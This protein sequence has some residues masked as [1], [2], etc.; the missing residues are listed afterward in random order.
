MKSSP[1]SELMERLVG[2]TCSELFTAYGVSLRRMPAATPLTEAWND[3]ASGGLV[4]FDSPSMTGSLVLV[5]TFR[6]LASCR[7]KEV[8]TRPL[9]RES[10]AD[11]ILVRDWTT[12]LVNQLLGRVRNRLYA[13]GVALD[14]KNPVALS[15]HSLGMAMKPRPKATFEFAAADG[16]IVRVWL[17]TR[18]NPTFA[19]AP[20]KDAA[21][22]P[23]EGDVL[24]F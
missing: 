15:G 2:E 24:L 12:E 13:R 19:P 23:E 5:G 17:D 11:W 7:P 21:A 6:F 9:K 8:R 3:E 22:V 20:P 18:F 14:W 1:P 16:Q 10:S 4:T